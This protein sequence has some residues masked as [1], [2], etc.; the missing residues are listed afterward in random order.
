MRALDALEP[1]VAAGELAGIVVASTDPLALELARLRGAVPL[2]ES[3]DGLNVALG[4]ARDVALARGARA[5]L[6][7]PADLPWLA[8]GDLRALLVLAGDAEVVLAPSRDGRGTNGLYTRPPDALHYAFGPNSCAEHLAQAETTGLR[9]R[10]CRTPGFAFDVDTPADLA[11]L[12]APG[13]RRAGR[14]PR[15]GEH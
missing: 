12:R 5:T 10:L 14:G 4:Q 11:A 1:L 6:V 3:G 13:E 7:V 8:P 2:R 15:A 9:A